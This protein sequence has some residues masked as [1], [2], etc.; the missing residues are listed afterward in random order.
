MK[1]DLRRHLLQTCT[2]QELKRWFDPLGLTLSKDN[3]H[4]NISFPHSY[5][6]E[7]FRSEVQDRFEDEVVRFMGRGYAINYQTSMGLSRADE[8]EK[9]KKTKRIDY[10][11][12]NQFTFES[13]LVNKKNYFPLASAREVAKQSD[14]IF[15]PFIICGKNGTG[16][17]HLIKA[18]A[19]EISKNAAPA[20]ILLASMDE[21][22]NIYSVTYGDDV[23]KARN[24]IF[25]FDHLLI[26]D[27]HQI[28]K[29]SGLQNEIIIL[30]NHFY[31][32]KKQ[33]VFCCPNKPSTYTFLDA[34]L[35]SRMEWGLIV[36]LKPPDL[37][38]RVE[39]IKEKCRIKNIPLTKDQILTLAQRFQDFRYLQ[40]TL[41]KL[42]AYRELVQKDMGDKNFQQLIS[43]TEEASAEALTHKAI[44]SFVS[45]AMNVPVSEITGTKRHQNIAMA[46]QVAMYLC[47]ELLGLSFPALGRIFGGKDHSTVLYSVKKIEQIK[48]DDKDLKR[49]LKDLKKRCLLS[50][51][52]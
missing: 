29:Y 33:M 45:E 47:R 46:R 15:N 49:L 26:D 38:V 52:N 2:D 8:K 48:D 28:Q 11:F 44:M 16:K 42:F 32:N 18:V 30:F 17:S 13:F 43:G 20:K 5:F 31:E 21:I 36:T 34:T 7:W 22:K 24:H 9:V 4:I 14:T 51:G 12:D 35:L 10:P 3:S 19:N 50:G 23:L 6:A 41:L 27:F 25:G 40:G 39:F 1:Q 37:E